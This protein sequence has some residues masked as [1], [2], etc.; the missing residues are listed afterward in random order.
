MGKD[1]I[2]EASLFP[3]RKKAAAILRQLVWFSRG[4][5]TFLIDPG[6]NSPP[7]YLLTHSIKHSP[8]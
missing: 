2:T 4:H 8:S 3:E 7:S 5:M 6:Q 1:R